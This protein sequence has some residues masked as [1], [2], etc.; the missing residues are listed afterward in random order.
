ME[1]DQKYF[2]EIGLLVGKYDF[3][4]YPNFLEEFVIHT[5]AS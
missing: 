1:V 3:F 4:A 5:D 2:K